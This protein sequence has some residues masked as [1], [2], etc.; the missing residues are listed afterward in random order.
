MG[1]VVIFCVGCSLSFIMGMFFSG[2]FY[3]AKKS[4]AELVNCQKELES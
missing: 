2:M 4:D 1:N 3:I